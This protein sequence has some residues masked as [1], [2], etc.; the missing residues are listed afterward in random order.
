[1][2]RRKWKNKELIK[3]KNENTF[4]EYYCEINQERAPQNDYKPQFIYNYIL[5]KLA[6]QKVFLKKK[7]EIE[8]NLAETQ[9][10]HFHIEDR[11]LKAKI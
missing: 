9:I 6:L 2:R 1:M 11:I 8:S 10:H 4:D 5:E 3:S 7:K